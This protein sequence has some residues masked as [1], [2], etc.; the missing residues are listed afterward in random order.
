MIVLIILGLVFL[1]L[2][3]LLI[4]LFTTNVNA[5]F[6]KWARKTAFIWLPIYGLKRLIKEV[7]FDKK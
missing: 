7:F 5:F 3:Y 4:D 1:L 6:D 2:I